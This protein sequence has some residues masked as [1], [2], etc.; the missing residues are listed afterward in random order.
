MLLK[1]FNWKREVLRS[2]GP[3]VVSFWARC[4]ARCRAMNPTA[5]AL[6]REF[7]VC[8]VNADKHPVLAAL[9]N[10]CSIPT[11]LIFKDGRVVA[12]HV[13]FTPEAALRSQ[14]R[15]ISR[16]RTAGRRSWPG[17]HLR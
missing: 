2:K 14:L 10:V 1:T 5:E 3:V 13:G 6:A 9:Y 4:C 15:E 7:K 8:Q 16:A 11:L 12:R 17:T